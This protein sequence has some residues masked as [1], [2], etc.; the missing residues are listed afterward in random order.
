MTPAGGIFGMVGLSF[1]GFVALMVALILVQIVALYMAT[2]FAGLIAGPGRA[3]L[4]FLGTVALSIPA[5]LIFG[6]LDLSGNAHDTLT[7]LV[8]LGAGT[9]SIKV[10]YRTGFVL[11]L[12]AYAL[13]AA[14]SLATMSAALLVIF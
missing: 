9:L 5:V 14:F 3:V 6:I 12:L 11:A 10:L 13:S 1:V 2:M 8:N 7:S 4:A